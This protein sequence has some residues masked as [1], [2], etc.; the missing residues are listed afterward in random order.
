[1]PAA[2]RKF[3]FDLDLERRNER[4]AV[5]SGSAISAMLAAARDE[6][7]REGCRHGEQSAVAE[8]GRRLAAAAEALAGRIAQSAADLDAARLQ[9]LADAVALAAAVGR[10]L[11]T[12]L[13]A[14]EPAAEIETLIAECL[15]SLDAVPHL[16]IRCAPDLAD[17]VRDI[18]TARIAESGFAG[19]LV[20]LGEPGIGPGDAR[21]EWADGGVVRDV[22]LLTAE[23][24]ARIDEFLTARGALPGRPEE[25]QQ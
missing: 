14:R 24:D 19:R 3:T 21:I 6:G 5:V 23:I 2:P 15:G 22:G 18:A 10:K 1:M 8:T 7:F 12:S 25:R 9:T 17:A 11:A 13:I 4:S 20:V 16:V